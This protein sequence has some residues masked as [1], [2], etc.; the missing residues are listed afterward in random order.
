[1]FCGKCGSPCQDGALFCAKCGN[2]LSIPEPVIAPEP[3]AQPI[4]TAPEQP[5]NAEPEQPIYAAPEQPAYVAPEQPAY[6]PQQSYNPQQPAYSPYQPTTEAPYSTPYQPNP[7]YPMPDYGAYDAQP[8]KKNYL[9]LIIGAVAAVAVIAV[10]LIFV[11]GGSGYSDPEELALDFA[12]AVSNLELDDLEDTMH[13][14][15]LDSE[16]WD[17][18][19]EMIEDAL[20]TVKE[21][22]Y[23]FETKNFEVDDVDYDFDREDLRDIEDYFE[24]YFDMDVK[25][26]DA[27]TYEISFDR[28]LNGEKSNQYGEVTVVKIDGAWY[29]HPE[30]ID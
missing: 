8:K 25:I 11:L 10:I 23:D 1:M 2:R 27:I 5:I 18:L 22:G 4:Y 30:S 21:R 16:R 14:D 6:Q 19:S 12:E 3:V 29:V 28:Y 20:E 9:P 24:G 17:D 26:E 15:V 13:P 7:G